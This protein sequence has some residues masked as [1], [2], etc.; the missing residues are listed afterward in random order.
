[1]VYVDREIEQISRTIHTSV[2]VEGG[3]KLAAELGAN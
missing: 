2:S 3:I 1:M